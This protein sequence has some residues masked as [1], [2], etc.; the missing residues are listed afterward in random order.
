VAGA[1]Q[2]TIDQF[3]SQLQGLRSQIQQAD[4]SLKA[5]AA[6]LGSMYATARAN[7]D[8]TRDAWIAP[9]IHRNNDLRLTYLKPVK[10]KFNEAVAI[11]KSAITSAGY[12][13][14]T[15]LGDLGQTEVIWVPAAAVAA[16]VL[17]ISAI[18]I[19]NRLTQA[20]ISRTAVL[21]S[22]YGD[23]TLTFDQKQVAAN[24]ILAQTKAE[25]KATPPP[26][27]FDLNALMGPLAIVAV[28]VLGPQIMRM[29]PKR[30]AA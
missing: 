29:L 24:G 23:H 7:Y 28:I 19:V 9:L 30:K 25:A 2:W 5:D 26:L 16:I 18:A 20:Q 13:V 3:W 22:I 21:A 12:S 15:Q 14:P 11:A 17:A 8:P 4:A 10:D 27:G 6:Q 1:I